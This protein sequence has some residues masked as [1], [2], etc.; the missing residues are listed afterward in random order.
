MKNIH[1]CK[2]WLLLEH[3]I[4]FNIVWIFHTQSELMVLT[5]TCACLLLLILKLGKVVQSFYEC[6]WGESFRTP[7]TAGNFKDTNPELFGWS[8]FLL[9]TITWNLSFFLK[10]WKLNTHLFIANFA[11]PITFGNFLIGHILPKYTLYFFL[12]IH[13]WVPMS[14]LLQ[15]L[16]HYTN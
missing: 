8:F 12:H 6:N 5:C 7:V 15:L 10:C 4:N 11:I 14:Y 9:L 1:L 2:Y 3:S 13:V 16:P